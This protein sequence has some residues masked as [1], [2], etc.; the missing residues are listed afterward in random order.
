[1]W[2]IC[3]LNVFCLF[4]SALFSA[5]SATLTCPEVTLIGLDIKDK[6]TILQG[7]T[8]FPGPAGSKGETGNTGIK[9]EKGAMGPQGAKGATGATGSK[10][11]SGSPGIPG[12]RGFQGHKGD[13]GEAGVLE[14]NTLDDLFCKKGAKTCKELQL[15]GNTVGGWYTIYPDGCTA[16][17]VLCDMENDGGG[18]TVFQRRWDGSV[19]FQRNWSAYKKG[20]GSQL[21]EFWLGNDNLNIL[22]SNGTYELRIE[23]R[24]Y[25]HIFYFA[26][27]NS[28]KVAGESD[29]YRITVG[30]LTASNAGDSFTYHNNQQFSTEDRDNDGSGSNCAAIKK[31]GWWYKDCLRSNLNGLYLRGMNVTPEIGINWLSGKGDKYSYKTSEMK[32]RPV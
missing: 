2:T 28:F 4:W 26:N 14:Q 6:V 10:G 22:T 13:K 31:G 3:L 21:T 16:M 17:P 30:S 1:M 32:I 5:A 15:R 19:G 9:G 23:L 12:V 29:K 24:D 27:Y 25:D 7:H 18:W 11:A 20:F 8:G